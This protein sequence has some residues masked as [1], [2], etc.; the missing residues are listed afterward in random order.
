MSDITL[1]YYLVASAMAFASINPALRA[2]IQDELEVDKKTIVSE[3]F[4]DR[5]GKKSGVLILHCVGLDDA[6][7]SKNYGLNNTNGGLGVSA[8]YY[9]SQESKKVYQ[10]VSE[11]LS[12]FHAGPSEWRSLAKENNLQGLNDISIGIEFQSP[13]YAQIKREAY[14]PYSFA[15]YSEEQINSGILLS[16]QIIKK[17]N[18]TPENVVWHSDVS[19]LRKTDPGALFD[20]RRFA[21]NGIGVWPSADRLEDNQLETSLSTIQ[22]GLKSWGYP[23]VETTDVFDNATK[24]VLTAHYMHYLP[25]EVQWEDFKNQASGSIFDTVQEWSDFPYQKDVLAISLENLNRKNFEKF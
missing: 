22:A 3:N 7:V 19:P 8:H 4:R 14:Y 25:Q 24:Y 2:M 23:H 1:K 5:N 10:L 16:K 9:V 21:Q 13:G 17:H 15:S 20:G 18:I 12:A 6:W 11:E